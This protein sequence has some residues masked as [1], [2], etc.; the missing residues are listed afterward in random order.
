[1]KQLVMEFLG[2]FFL[3][4]VVAF[5]GHP[6]AIGLLLMAMVYCGGHISGGHYNPAVSLTIFFRGLIS[7]SQLGLYM[8][9]QT[10]GA[11]CAAFFF[12]YI[13]STPFVA[14]SHFAAA[15]L[16]KAFLIELVFT[17]VLCLTVVMVAT[18]QAVPHNSIFGIAIGGSLVCIAAIGGIYNP[19][20][21]LGSA[22]AE[23]AHSHLFDLK[24]IGVYIAGPLC[25]ALV[26][27]GL[28]K[29][30]EQN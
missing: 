30:F 3:A 28:F 8:L 23:Y 20:I 11:L 21:A 27:A 19:A 17:I 7:R 25:G 22:L 2:T 24:A 14:A 26:T 1:M 5:T 29:Y 13:T 9:A 4:A 12:N 6:V 10:A 18:T 15:G 16:E